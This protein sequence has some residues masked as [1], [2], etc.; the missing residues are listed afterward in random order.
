MSVKKR[1]I[2]QNNLRLKDYIKISFSGEFSY[3]KL[4]EKKQNRRGCYIL[5]ESEIKYNVYYIDVCTKTG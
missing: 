3:A 5:R 4:E 1:I 2:I